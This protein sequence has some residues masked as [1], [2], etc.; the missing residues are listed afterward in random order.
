MSYYEFK[1]DSRFSKNL[2]LFAGS[3][4]NFFSPQIIFWVFYLL[5]SFTNLTN[6]WPDWLP[7]ILFLASLISGIVLTI[8]LLVCRKGVFLY[9]NFMEISRHTITTK[10]YNMNIKISYNEI[11]RIYVNYQ[12]LRST[13]H[14]RD[15]LVLFGARSSYVEIVLKNGKQYFF[16]VE[17]QEQFCEEVRMH[18]KEITND[19][20]ENES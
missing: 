9:K 15:L 7:G 6:H 11:E 14:Y 19:A 13:S 8:R 3:V 4:Q 12:N 20:S 17:N 18:L 16:A 2:G 5:L 1:Y 10:N